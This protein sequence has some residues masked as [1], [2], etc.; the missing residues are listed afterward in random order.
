LEHG[1][2]NKSDGGK[3]D[4]TIN[5]PSLDKPQNE[6]KKPWCLGQEQGCARKGREIACS[7]SI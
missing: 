2:G 5:S 4:V 6:S 1:W 7:D 3:P